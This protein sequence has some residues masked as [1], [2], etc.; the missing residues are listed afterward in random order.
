MDDLLSEVRGEKMAL[1]EGLERGAVHKVE[2][3]EEV[4]VAVASMVVSVVAVASVV[5]SVVVAVATTPANVWYIRL[6]ILVCMSMSR[7][8]TIK[9]THYQISQMSRSTNHLIDPLLVLAKLY[10]CTHHKSMYKI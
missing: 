1:V 8:T 7:Y 4:M 2:E 6:L 9:F 10:L 3:E 5:A